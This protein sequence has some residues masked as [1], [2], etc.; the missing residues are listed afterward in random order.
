MW[1]L[2]P[3]SR[4]RDWGQGWCRGHRRRE[5]RGPGSRFSSGWIRRPGAGPRPR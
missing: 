2:T 4:C 1:D 3:A 5:D